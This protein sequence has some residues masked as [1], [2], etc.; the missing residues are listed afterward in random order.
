MSQ[1]GNMT[2]DRLVDGLGEEAAAAVADLDLEER[3]LL[4]ACIAAE[5]KEIG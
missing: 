1:V 5:A 2:D 4:A 3:E